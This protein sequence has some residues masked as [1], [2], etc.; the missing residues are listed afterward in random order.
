SGYRIELPRAGMNISFAA[1]LLLLVGAWTASPAS[2][3]D[4]PTKPV[5]IVVPIPP[6]SSPDVIARILADRL[7]QQWKQQVLVVNKPGGS[8]M[9]AAQAVA[10]AP[11]DGYTL[12]MPLASAFTVLPES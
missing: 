9:I 6:G 5:S 4:Y 8:G 11:P 7:S 2:A 1:T 12:Y 10:I 3:D